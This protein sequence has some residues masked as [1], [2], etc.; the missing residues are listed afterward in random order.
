MQKKKRLILFT[1]A[2]PEF[3]KRK[4]DGVEIWGNPVSKHSEP[5][6][7][8]YS[9]DGNPMEIPPMVREVPSSTRLTKRRLN[10]GGWSAVVILV[11]VSLV[12]L[13]R[14]AKRK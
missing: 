5:F 7:L 12:S 10:R 9:R 8:L 14:F 4:S 13:L 6:V 11:T 2:R 1:D 3:I